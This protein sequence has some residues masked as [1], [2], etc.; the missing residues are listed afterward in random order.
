MAEQLL[1][2]GHEVEVVTAR[3]NYPR[4]R[5]LDER[6]LRLYVREVRNG[7][8]VHR[9]WVYPAMGSG[10]GRV[11]NCATF[12]VTSLLGLFRA[13]RPDYLLVE[14]PPLL[15][16]IPAYLVKLVWRVPYIFNVADLWPDAMIEHGFLREGL[17]QQ[18]LL[19]LESWSYRKAAYVNAVTQ[20]IR[21]VLVSQKHVPAE[22]V[23][24]LP[25]GV[26]LSRFQRREPDL[27]LKRELG[28][29]DKSVILWAGTMGYAHGLEYVLQAAK[30]LEG[31]S[32]IHFLFLGDGST[33]NKLRQLR[34]QLN[35]QNVTFRDP[36]SLEELPP[37]YSIA[38]G[39]LASLR[40]LPSHEGARPSKIFPVLA[41]GKALIFVGSGEGARLV[42][43]AQAGVVV[44]PENPPALAKE[45]LRLFANRK[46]L[47][48][49]GENGRR[50]AETHLQWS[51]LV[52]SWLEN[53]RQ[54]QAGP[55]NAIRI[56][57]TS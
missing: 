13:R 24:F 30:I 18:M 56:S 47:L 48:Q 40:A 15:T 4:G 53:L 41:S 3:P 31:H 36:V 22:K 45:I 52:A 11:M 27:R 16:C 10:L 35:L 8:V 49:L 42:E 17:L 33:R 21:D 23:L 46:M 55:A 14:S 2:L 6:G 57:A 43:S 7:I 39:C 32:H 37:Y 9:V 29:E 44:E 54:A 12:G 1:R 38:E 26:D 51:N 5:F 50:F 25:N 20:G 28:L 19:A 34:T